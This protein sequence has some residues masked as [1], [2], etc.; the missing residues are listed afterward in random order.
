MSTKELGVV[1]LKTAWPNTVSLSYVG[2]V[3]AEDSETVTLANPIRMIEYL[4]T[5]KVRDNSG[6]LVP[7]TAVKFAFIDDNG[8]TELLINKER[9][10]AALGKPTEVVKKSYENMEVQRRA[11]AAGLST[12][13][14]MT[15]NGLRGN[16]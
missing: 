11:A 12:P 14:H 1:R 9:E 15:D 8:F 5:E 16:A 2:I 7:T 3:V 4:E 10:V 13:R 6:A